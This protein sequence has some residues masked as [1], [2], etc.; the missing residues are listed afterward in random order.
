MSQPNAIAEPAEFEFEAL[1]EA[2]NY[3]AALIK[4]FDPY[5]RGNVLEVGAGVGQFTRELQRRSNIQRLVS[6]E[7]DPTFCSAFRTTLPSRELVE[8]TVNDLRSATDWNAIFSVNVLEHIETDCEELE[9]YCRLLRPAQGALCLF[10]PARPEIYAPIDKDFGHFRRYTRRELKTKLESAGFTLVRF[11]YFNFVGYF[12]W[13][14]T[15]C[16]LR[17]RTF[18]VSLVRLF[19]R[20]I[21]P[22]V[23]RFESNICAPPFGQSLFVVAVA[24]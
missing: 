13:W 6:I 17:K 11:R 22:A 5:L 24:R 1:R 7:L 21:F 19:D 4:D 10:V 9:T 16:L 8:G 15:F 23:H 3:R 20:V 18:D 14:L 12:L 2:E